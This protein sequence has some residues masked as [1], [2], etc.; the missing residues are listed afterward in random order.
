MVNGLLKNRESYFFRGLVGC[1]VR[2]RG[3]KSDVMGFVL[4]IREGE[5]GRFLFSSSFYIIDS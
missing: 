1:K 2:S 3:F 5:E 4:Y